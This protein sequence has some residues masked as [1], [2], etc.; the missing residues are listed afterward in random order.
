V[1]GAAAIDAIVEGI[2][3]TGGTDGAALA[4]AF[5]GFSGVP[6]LSGDVSFSP[7]LHSVFGREY[8]VMEI[9]DGQLR[10][11]ELFAA[12]SPATLPG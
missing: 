12:S 6:T 9:Q 3:Q 11:I 8:R 4:E 10:F 5:E 2:E 7:E 1:T